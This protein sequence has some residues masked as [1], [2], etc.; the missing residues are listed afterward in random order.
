MWDKHGWLDWFWQFLSDGLSFFNPKGFCYS[1]GWSCSLFEG[2][3]FFLHGTY[4]LKTLQILTYVLNWLYFTQCLIFFLHL[5]S[6]L[7]LCTVFDAIFSDID[8]DLS[9]NP[10]AAFVFGDF[11]DYLH[12]KTILCDKVALD[13]KLMIFFIWRKNNVSAS[14]YRSFCVFLKPEDLKI[15]DV[16]ISVAA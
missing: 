1:Y 9:I 2:R 6:F 3:T 8:E 15:C 12:Y 7:S 14:R 4:L 10:S 13:V 5:L 11:K 16:I